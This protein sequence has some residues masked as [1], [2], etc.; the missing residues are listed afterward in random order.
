M[1]RSLFAGV[2]ALRYHQVRMDVIGNN[3]ANVNTV[4][5]KSSRVTFK[6]LLSQTLRDASAPQNNRGG[7]NPFQVGLGVNLGAIHTYHTQGNPQA[8][9]VA[10]DLAIEGDG[11]FIL[12]NGPERFYT[13]AG[14]FDLDRDGNL[15]S[16]TTGLKVLGVG[17]GPE[18][19]DRHQR[20]AAGDRHPQ[21]GDHRSPGHVA[22]RLHGQLGLQG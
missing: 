3:I 10:T 20:P 2:S 22:D 5:Y 15:V 16:L 14:M 6:D 12:S 11:Y 17:G 7:T 4:G 9:G 1:M 19:R 8:T 18:R 21:G 13:R